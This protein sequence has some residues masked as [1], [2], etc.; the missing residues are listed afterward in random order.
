VR[1]FKN[2]R[3]G[4]V[5]CEIEN[6]DNKLCDYGCGQIAKFQFGN[7]KYCCSN[8][9]NRCPIERE[10]LSKSKKGK[11]SYR[12]KEIENPNEIVCDYGC[13][14]I[15]KFQFHNKKYCCSDNARKCLGSIKKTS[16]AHIG[17]KHL[18]NKE[19]ENPDGILCD[20]G[21][22]Q[23]AK[24]QLGNGKYCCSDHY[25][26][27]LFMKKQRFSYK[28]IENHDNKLCDYGCG[29]IAK[30]QF[31]NG[32]YC[33]SSNVKKCGGLS[34]SLS[35]SQLGKKI[36]ESIKIENLE[37]KLCDYGCGKI[38]KFEFQNKKICCHDHYLK[39]DS[40]KKYLSIIEVNL[41]FPELVLIENLKEGSNG[42]VLGKCKNSN[43]TKNKETDGYF[44]LTT[45]QIYYRYQGINSIRDGD[46]FYCCEECKKECVL[47]GKSAKQLDNIFSPEGDLNQA[48]QQDLLT[49]RNEVLA[50]QLLENKEHNSNYCEI[51]HKTENL[52]AHHIQPQKLEPGYALDP[53]NGIIL[54]LKCHKKYGHEI[55]SIC[56]IGNLAN[57]ICK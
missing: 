21:C 47:F 50:R 52:Q 39:C 42:E 51:C 26:K 53:I 44:I 49:W 31:G 9:F 14:Q 55:G 18:K 25:I 54:C 7:G 33:C 19:I 24:F 6:H 12:F 2:W 17:K 4:M 34:K 45:S 32:K 20:Y 35:K 3:V 10:K 15:A 41:R 43:C 28:E 46:Y 27:C 38:A 57:K 22:G 13:G 11:K 37:N 23:I 36:R 1:W 8:V 30:F 40:N 56:S 48:S 16:T 29:Q 5:K